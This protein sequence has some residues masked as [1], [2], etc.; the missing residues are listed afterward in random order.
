MDP[1]NVSYSLKDGKIT[2]HIRLRP[3]VEKMLYGSP[4]GGGK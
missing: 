3:D 2:I 4:S 1:L